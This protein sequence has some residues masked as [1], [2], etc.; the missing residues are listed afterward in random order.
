MLL[1]A[2]TVCAC[3]NDWERIDSKQGGVLFFFVGSL[4]LFQTDCSTCCEVGGSTIRQKGSL[5]QITRRSRTVRIWRNST[6]PA[7]RVL[8]PWLSGSLW[9]EGPCTELGRFFEVVAFPMCLAV[10]V[11]ASCLNWDPGAR[12]SSRGANLS[13]VCGKRWSDGMRVLGQV[14]T[15]PLE[16]HVSESLVPLLIVLLM[17]LLLL[18]MMINSLVANHNLKD[19]L[20]WLLDQV[21]ESLPVCSPIPYGWQGCWLDRSWL[22]NTSCPTTS[23]FIS[24]RSVYLIIFYF[25]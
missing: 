13:V 1:K 14:D 15:G 19:F 3:W 4:V 23:D 20:S 11:Q 22:A 16:R 7:K 21:R 25:P 2:D 12:Q 9:R 5:F 17:M 10:G 24:W 18:M 6:S 8:L